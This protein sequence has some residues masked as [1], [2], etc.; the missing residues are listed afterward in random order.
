M[1]CAFET[2]RLLVDDWHAGSRDL[3][4]IVEALMTERVTRSLPTPWRG[5][6][7]RERAAAWVEDRDA[8]GITLLVVDRSNDQAIGLLIVFPIERERRFG[9]L[10]SESS[11]GK[12]LG[13]ELVAGFVDWCREQED[14]ASLTGGVEAGN[15]GSRRVLEKCGF[16]RVESEGDEHLYRL[17]LCAK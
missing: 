11:W 2:P 17:L 12:G 13:S 16:V 3:A 8:E 14:I 5:E 4:E 7:T 6:Y 1:K 9:F 10:L 15:H